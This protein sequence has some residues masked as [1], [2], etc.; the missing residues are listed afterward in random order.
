M[1]TMKLSF[2]LAAL[3]IVLG[4]SVLSTS[5]HADP[6]KTQAINAAT[7]K[8]KDTAAKVSN[9]NSTVVNTVANT[10]VILVGTS[11]LDPVVAARVLYEERLAEREAELEAEEIFRKSQALL[12]ANDPLLSESA[13]E[14]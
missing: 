4:T 14:P 8:H 7:S 11:A 5:I 3:L 2:K 12:L 13:P 10:P 6:K 9:K 1:N